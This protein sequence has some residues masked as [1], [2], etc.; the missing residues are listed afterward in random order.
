[1]QLEFAVRMEAHC[2]FFQQPGCHSRG[3]G[4]IA[5]HGVVSDGQA[6]L[7][8]DQARA[9]E[10]LHAGMMAPVV[11]Q[12]FGVLVALAI[13]DRALDIPILTHPIAP[14]VSPAESTRR[15]HGACPGPL[16]PDGLPGRNGQCAGGALGLGLPTAQDCV[17]VRCAS[18]AQDLKTAPLSVMPGGAKV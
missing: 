14:V 15:L 10:L 17:R 16:G 4:E 6:G 18:V 1:M 11:D 3:R 12:V 9:A 13:P 2:G 8:L 7:H 5:H